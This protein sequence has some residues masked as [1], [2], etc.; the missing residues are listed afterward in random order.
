MA[1]KQ[2]HSRDARVR[3][4]PAAGYATSADAPALTGIL[5]D[6]DDVIEVLRGNPDVVRSLRRLERESVPTYCTAFSW[7]EIYSGI[8]RGEEPVMETSRPAVRS[9][10][11][12]GPDG[13]RE[14][15]WR[16]SA[17]RTASRSPTR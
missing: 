3:E 16:V 2:R 1:R 5:L 4:K 6:S 14:P 8:R 10:W 13:R 17:G 7:A 11:I 9:S 15:T 12:R